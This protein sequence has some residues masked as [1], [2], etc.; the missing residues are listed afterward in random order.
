M[1]QYL[2]VKKYHQNIALNIL[3]IKESINVLS[4]TYA[5]ATPARLNTLYLSLMMLDCVLQVVSFMK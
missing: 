1:N 4:K 2:F 3:I 5:L